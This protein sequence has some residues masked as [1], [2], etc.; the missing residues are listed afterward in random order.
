MGWGRL[1]SPRRGAPA[2]LSSSARVFL[3]SLAP[4]PCIPC[5]AAKQQKACGQWAAVL[6]VARSCN[7][8]NTVM[9]SAWPRTA[10][11]KALHVWIGHLDRVCSPRHLDCE[12]LQQRRKDPGWA[13]LVTFH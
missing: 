1:Q 9:L 11:F 4:V 7:S 12:F 8:R 13:C 2:P 10:S 5:V 3:K 6:T